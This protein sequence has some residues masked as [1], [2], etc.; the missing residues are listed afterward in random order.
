MESGLTPTGFMDGYLMSYQTFSHHYLLRGKLAV[1]T[2]ES[3]SIISNVVL[4]PF[5]VKRVILTFYSNVI[6]ALM[7]IVY[8]T[9]KRDKIGWKIN[10]VS[11]PKSSALLTFVLKLLFQ[12]SFAKE[13]G[14]INGETKMWN[15][16]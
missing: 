15:E 13:N 7:C 4:G 6:T 16:A 2:G 12:N 10:I 5:T 1:S 3:R 14:K 11:T 8:D 9:M